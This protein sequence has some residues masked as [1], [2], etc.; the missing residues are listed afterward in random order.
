M[1]TASPTPALSTR[2]AL[3]GFGAWGQM[4]ARAIAAIDG[5]EVV[6]V[7]ARSQTARAA[8]AELLPAARVYQDYAALLADQSVEIVSVVLPNHAHADAA[9]A[10]L[11]AGKHV[12]LEKPLGLTLAQCDAV[13]LAMRRNDRLVA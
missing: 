6:A 8:A 10:A 7:L 12:F 13:A 4:H 2:V 11:D 9:I 3:A 5:A 1:S